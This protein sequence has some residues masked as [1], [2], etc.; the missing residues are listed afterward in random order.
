MFMPY[1]PIIQ[2]GGAWMYKLA[3]ELNTNNVKKVASS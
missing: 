3:K 2:T 1:L